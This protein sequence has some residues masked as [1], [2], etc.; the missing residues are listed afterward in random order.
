MARTGPPT[1]S[2]LALNHRPKATPM[3]PNL[4]VPDSVVLNLA[5]VLRQW[6]GWFRPVDDGRGYPY[7]ALRGSESWNAPTTPGSAATPT[8]PDG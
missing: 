1:W 2:R 5:P 8:R 7:H 4:R 3:A 6:I